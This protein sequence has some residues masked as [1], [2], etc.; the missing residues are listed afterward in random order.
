MNTSEFVIG[1][2]DYTEALCPICKKYQRL[3]TG[4]VTNTLVGPACAVCHHHYAWEDGRAML[5]FPSNIGKLFKRMRD[6]YGERPVAA[7]EPIIAKA[8]P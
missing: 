2:W 8:I 5:V 1:L 7:D 3:T 4:F 6:V